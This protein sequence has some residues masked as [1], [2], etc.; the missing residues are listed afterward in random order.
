LVDVP[1]NWTSF[2]TVYDGDAESGGEDVG[3]TVSF[4][5]C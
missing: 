1:P 5:Q 3:L 4:D 2:K